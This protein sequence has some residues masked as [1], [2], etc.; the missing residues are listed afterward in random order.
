MESRF[1]KTCCGIAAARARFTRQERSWTWDGFVFR[2]APWRHRTLRGHADRT[3]RARCLQPNPRLALAG[4]GVGDDTRPTRM[5]SRDGGSGRDGADSQSRRAGN[6]IGNMAVVLVVVLVFD[7]E[8]RRYA[9][10]R[11]QER[12][13]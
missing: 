3:R 5:V 9:R 4:A 10:R 6:A 12:E 11:G 1:A 2:N 7:L 13:R 8:T